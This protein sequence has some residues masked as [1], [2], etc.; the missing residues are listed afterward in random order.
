M[1]KKKNGKLQT[2]VCRAL[3]HS[4][5]KL[6]Q[7][8]QPFN[9]LAKVSPTTCVLALPRLALAREGFEVSAPIFTSPAFDLISKWG[10]A[11]HPIQ[12]KSGS[13]FEN[14]RRSSGIRAP[15]EGCTRRKIAAILGWCL[16]RETRS[17]GF[18]FRKPLGRSRCAPTSKMIPSLA[19]ALP[20]MASKKW[21][22]MCQQQFDDSK[23]PS[24]G[25]KMNS[26]LTTR[27]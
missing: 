17:G 18:R 11:V 21:Q 7:K 20:Q 12:V 16:S 26:E 13:L 1:R 19:T 14:G 27:E 25:P 10:R 5:N 8:A 2:A 6:P 9:S 4:T 22:Q 24:T 23:N 3:D 15:K